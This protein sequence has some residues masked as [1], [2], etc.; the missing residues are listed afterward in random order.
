[1]DYA[2]ESGV[3]R[4]L[5]FNF[6]DVQYFRKSLYRI[7]MQVKGGMELSWNEKQGAVEESALY[8]FMS[9]LRCLRVRSCAILLHRDFPDVINGDQNDHNGASD[10]PKCENE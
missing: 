4:Y 6:L 1:M 10:H 9:L 8:K 3:V 7:A 5:G 2:H